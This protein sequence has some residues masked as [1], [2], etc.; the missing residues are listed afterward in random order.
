MS[1]TLFIAYADAS[2]LGVFFFV[3]VFPLVAL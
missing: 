2:A 3:A 1:L